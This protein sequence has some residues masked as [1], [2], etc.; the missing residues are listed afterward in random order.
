MCVSHASLKKAFSHCVGRGEWTV[1]WGGGIIPQD[2]WAII[3]H[4]PAHLI[5]SPVNPTLHIHRK[6]PIVFVQ[7]AFSSQSSMPS[8]HSSMSIE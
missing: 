4:I 8:L 2:V 1:C 7:F 3:D 5:P 6:L